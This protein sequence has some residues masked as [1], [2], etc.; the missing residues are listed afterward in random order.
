MVVVAERAGN[1]SKLIGLLVWLMNQQK[2]CKQYQIVGFK[3]AMTAT[4]WLHLAL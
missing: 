4:F 3:Y 2:N 1:Q